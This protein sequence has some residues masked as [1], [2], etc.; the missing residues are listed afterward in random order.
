MAFSGLP[1]ND[2]PIVVKKGSDGKYQPAEAL[3]IQLIDPLAAA[4][5]Q[6]IIAADGITV[7]VLVGA[8]NELGA[9]EFDQVNPITLEAFLADMKPGYYWIKAESTDENSPYDG[10]VYSSQFTAVEQYDLAIAPADDMS[11]NGVVETVTVG[12]RTV[13]LDA[14]GAAQTTAQPAEKVTIKAKKGYVIEEVKVGG[15]AVTITIGDVTLDITGCT[16]WADAVAKN[17]DVIEV[18]YSIIMLKG[19]LYALVLNNTGVKS[20]DA[21]DTSANYIWRQNE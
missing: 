13:T 10:T 12:T 9:I 5:A 20:T 11:K 4:E 7:K 3:T 14:D 16:T 21:I 17:S 18:K 1:T 2:E 8:E 6:N 15:P 19:G